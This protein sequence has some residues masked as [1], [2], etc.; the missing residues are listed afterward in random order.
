MVVTDWGGNNDRVAAVKAG[1]SLEMP[2]SGGLT[3]AEIVQA[4]RSGELE[5]SLLDEAVERYLELLF[6]TRPAWARASASTI[7]STT[8][9]P[10]R[11]RHAL[12]C[13]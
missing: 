3:D 4:V 10:G 5:E 11:L 12:R 6:A 7:P 1:C 2:A 9:Q 8:R 13:C